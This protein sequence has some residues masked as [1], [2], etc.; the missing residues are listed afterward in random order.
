MKRILFGRLVTMDQ[1]GVLPDGAIYVDGNSITAVAD[2]QAPRPDGYADVTGV[3]TSGTIFPGLIELHNHLSYDALPLWKVPKK[4]SDRGQWQSNADYEA[5]VSGPMTTI[6]KSSD[7]RLLA[8]LARYVETKC[9]FGGVSTSQGI[10]LKSDHMEQSYRSAMR[11][12]DDPGDPQFP[13]AATHIPDVDATDWSAF[14]KALNK[15]SC[16]LLHLSEGVDEKARDAF[17]ALQHE[18][19]WAITPALAGIH[20]VAL[21]AEDFAIMKQHGGSVV[22]SPLSNLM[23]YGGTTNIKAARQAGITLALG[24]DWSPS[25]SKNLLNELK[26]AKAASDVLGIGLS[27]KDIVA[28][29]TASPAAIVKWDALVGSIT[30]GKRADLIVIGAATGDPYTS[31]IAA[32]ETDVVLLM[33]DGQAVMGTPKLMSKL[34]QD[35]ESLHL[36][37]ATRV[38]NYGPGDPRVPPVTF[39]EA[40]AAMADAFSRLP[41]LLSDEKAGKGVAGHALAGRHDVARPMLRLALHEEHLTDF[42]LRPRLPFGGRPT[43]PDAGLNRATLAAATAAPVGPVQLDPPSVADDPDYASALQGLVNVPVPIRQA[44]KTYY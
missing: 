15:A 30:A 40:K 18:G 1:A 36:G 31:L 13:D 10:S 4:F 6:A 8:S 17:L 33:I 41:T 14:L 24:S 39:A 16:M 3:E 43:G 28:M 22:W 37:T 19:K 26:V 21:K 38:V 11:V 23:L 42:A 12:V 2:R 7:L 29:V 9:L 5:K 20:C 34:G 27:D 25:G 35:G 44:L 32:H